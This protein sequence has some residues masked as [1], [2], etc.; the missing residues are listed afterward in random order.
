MRDETEALRISSENIGRYVAADPYR[1]P[2]DGNL[3]P[4]NTALIIIDMQVDFCG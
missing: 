3:T 4:A 1:W 2:Y